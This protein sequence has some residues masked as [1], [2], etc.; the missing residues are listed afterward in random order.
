MTFKDYFSGH[1]S[2][3]SE[4]RPR[5]PQA[6]V[7]L[8][9]AFA[10]ACRLA[11][12][13]GCGNGQLSTLLADRFERVIATDASGAQLAAATPHEGVEYRCA[14]AESS[15]LPDA[16]VDLTT[17]AQAAHW[18]ELSA[19]YDEVRRVSRGPDSVLA[20]ISYGRHSVEPGVDAVV[21]RF[22]SG[23]LARYWPKERAH[24]DSGYSTLPFPFARLEVP[25]LAIEADWSVDE[26][27]AYIETWSAVTRLV[28][29][30]GSAPLDAFR[31]EV[32]RT[33]TDARLRGVRWPLTVLAGRVGSEGG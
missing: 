17:V 1:A 18:F 10:P 19:F 21:E 26:M 15:G 23:V 2:R 12:D 16:S 31:E 20:L 28:R 4:A 11:W 9:G 30:E 22:Y 25:P 6:L 8:L 27:L 5:Y 13:C 29:E 3:Y 7:E 24:V 14:R 33:W 32:R